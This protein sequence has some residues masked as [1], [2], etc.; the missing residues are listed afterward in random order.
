MR[1]QEVQR[2]FQK[3][4]MMFRRVSWFKAQLWFIRFQD[5]WSNILPREQHAVRVTNYT[6]I[7]GM[8]RRQSLLQQQCELE[9]T[10]PGP[11]GLMVERRTTKS[12]LTTTPLIIFTNLYHTRM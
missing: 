12:C 9:G 5:H 4:L 10:E 11:L 3:L 1:V 2:L 6:Y 8:Y 7:Y